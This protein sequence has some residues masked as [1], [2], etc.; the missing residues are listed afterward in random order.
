M[1][2][3]ILFIILIV[4]SCSTKTNEEQTKEMVKANFEAY[5]NE[6]LHDP[7]GYEFVKIS[8]SDTITHLQNLDREIEWKQS[9]NKNYQSSLED[10][11]EKMSKIDVIRKE[12]EFLFEKIKENNEALD[13]LFYS[14]E[15][16]LK[17]NKDSIAW[18]TCHVVFRAHNGNGAKRLYDRF[19]AV[20]AYP[21]YEVIEL[22]KGDDESYLREIE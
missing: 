17:H 7:E 13:S 3:L 6:R 11:T 4:T 18:I 9:S 5:L 21:D 19:I 1:R 16:I 14:K 15:Q 12:K 22:V 20:E 10:I 2:V 8:I